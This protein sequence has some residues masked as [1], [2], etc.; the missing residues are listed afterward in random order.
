MRNWIHQWSKIVVEVS[1]KGYVYRWGSSQVHGLDVGTLRLAISLTDKGEWKGL[2]LL[3]QLF[4]EHLLMNLLQ[5]SALAL[6]RGIRN[7]SHRH[8]RQNL[9]FMKKE[10]W[11][12]VEACSRFLTNVWRKRR[13][14]QMAMALDKPLNSSVSSFVKMG[15]I[16]FTAH[17]CS[18]KSNELMCWNCF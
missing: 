9:F 10:F 5:N 7:G 18:N 2:I 6:Q 3:Y 16:S 12:L 17:S 4:P 1:R 8:G 11:S 13:T 14:C 15:I